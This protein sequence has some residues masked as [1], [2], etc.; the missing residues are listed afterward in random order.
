M[1]ARLLHW[2]RGVE[3]QVGTCNRTHI[4]AEQRHDG[5]D[6]AKTHLLTAVEPKPTRACGKGSAVFREWWERAASRNA[7]PQGSDLS[8]LCAVPMPQP[9]DGRITIYNFTFNQQKGHIYSI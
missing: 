9:A 8:L 7:C 5:G 3:G 4:L 2:L 6:G 1:T